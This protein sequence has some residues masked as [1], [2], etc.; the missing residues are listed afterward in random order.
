VVARAALV[1]LAL[2]VAGCGSDDSPAAPAVD[3]KTETIDPLPKLPPGFEPHIS[4][5]NGLAIGRPPGW[6]AKEVGTT[7][8]LTAP[9]KLVV[10][11]LLA[12]RTTEQLAA[13]PS[14]LV[15][16]T[17]HVLEGYEGALD[18]SEPKRFE[19]PYEAFEVK[20]TGVS[21][22][23]GVRT[24]L[25]VVVL[26]R[27]GVALVTAVIAE[28]AK[29]GAPAEVVQALEALRTLRTRPVG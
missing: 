20:G 24:R 18:P 25:R 28:N 22:Q 14:V 10:M 16:R 8:V 21:T 9:D 13:D 1:I 15:V 2:A 26:E 17:F 7:T 19:Q 3:R 27:E 4:H 12:D 6:T 5:V 23:T 29:V 11:S